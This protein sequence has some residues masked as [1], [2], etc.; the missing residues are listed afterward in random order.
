MFI[1]P[2]ANAFNLYQAKNMLFN[3]EL[4]SWQVERDGTYKPPI[5]MKIT[6]GTMVGIRAGLVGFAADCLAQACVIATRYSA[7]RRQTEIKPGW[8]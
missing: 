8:V 7:V 6:Y 4:I 5:S 2:S 1:L 3:K